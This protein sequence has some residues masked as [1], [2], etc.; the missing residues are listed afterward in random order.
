[1]KKD[2]P[3]KLYAPTSWN[4]L[5]DSQFKKIA[6]ILM[7]KDLD[8]KHQKKVFKY[9]LDIKWW[10]FLKRAKFKLLLRHI[11]LSEL[12]NQ[13]SFLFKENNRTIFPKAFKINKTIYH[14]P[15]DRIVNLTAD[16]F[17]AA[18]GFHQKWRETKNTEYLQYLAAT[19]YTPHPRPGFNKL[20]LDTVVK[21]F[22][23]LPLKS[24]LAIELTFFGCKNNLAARFKKV[25]SSGF[26]KSQKKYG[27]GKVILEMAKGD[28]SKHPTVKQTNIFTFLEQFQEDIITS[29]KTQQ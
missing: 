19:L 4:E 12:R 6:L 13:F 7:T 16:E 22:K 1:M 17:A 26:K 20:D 28:L 23:K 15:M 2:K 27:F 10:H 8:I 29:T 5:K 14:P 18:D 9:L 24:L 3:L 25:F 11:T 21:P